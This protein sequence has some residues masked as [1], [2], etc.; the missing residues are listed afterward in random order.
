MRA[1]GLCP[2]K[3]PFPRINGQPVEFVGSPSN[4]RVL[5]RRVDL[6]RMSDATWSGA[7]SRP[8]GAYY[9]AGAAPGPHAPEWLDVF[10][11]RQGQGPD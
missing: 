10:G 2:K 8:G 1:G 6:C 11:A 5:S 7:R 9:A 4:A 3:T